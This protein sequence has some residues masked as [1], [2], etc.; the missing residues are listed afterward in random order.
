MSGMPITSFSGHYRFLS[1]F[2]CKDLTYQGIKYPS[3]ENAYQA[4]KAEDTAS[5]AEFRGISPGQAKR[6]GQRLTL[7]P[8]WEDLKVAIMLEILK[9]KFS[10]SFL[11]Q[12]LRET[13]DAMLIEGNTWGDTFWGVCNGVGENKLGKLLM[14]VRTGLSR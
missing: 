3:S 9:I 7:R 11:E 8:N 4:S 12:K 14:I 2:Y 6:L 10:D 13:G 1:N 5:R